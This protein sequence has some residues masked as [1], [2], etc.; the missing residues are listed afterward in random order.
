[1]LS[2]RLCLPKIDISLCNVA[3]E[4]SLFE[5]VELHSWPCP[6]NEYLLYEFRIGE[7]LSRSG[8]GWTNHS[9]PHHHGAIYHPYAQPARVQTEM[10]HGDI[11]PT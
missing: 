4:S 10:P 8:F 9:P 7:V 5:R 6:I 11:K 2:I 3:W 1:M